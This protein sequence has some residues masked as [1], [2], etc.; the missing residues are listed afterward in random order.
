MNYNDETKGNNLNTSDNKMGRRRRA[1]K[2]IKETKK[3]V[4]AKQFRCPHC[5]TEDSVDCSFNKD[6]QEATLQCRN[7]NR[8]YETRKF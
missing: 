6:A 7:C 2:K 1:A 8:K 5:S 4:V 3:L